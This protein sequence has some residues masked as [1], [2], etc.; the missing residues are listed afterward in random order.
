[1]FS[2]P[3]TKLPNFAHPLAETT[4]A[5]YVQLQQRLNFLRMTLRVRSNAPEPRHVT[6]VRNSFGRPVN[7][8]NPGN[9]YQLPART[10]NFVF[11]RFAPKN[12]VAHSTKL[13]LRLA[14][15]A[16]LGRRATHRQLPVR[17]PNAP[18]TKREGKKNFRKTFFQSNFNLPQTLAGQR[19]T[20]LPRRHKIVGYGTTDQNSVTASDIRLRAA[21]NQNPCV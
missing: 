17:L 10:Q 1:M 20:F 8:S 19:A 9:R 21:L 4:N 14:R 16:L 2:L 15:N 12:P 11:R 3:T 18:V 5:R 6:R 7:V 13:S